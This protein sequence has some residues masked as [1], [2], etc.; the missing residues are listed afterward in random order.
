MIEDLEGIVADEPDAEASG[1]AE[2]ALE[3]LRDFVATS[4]TI[5]GVQEGEEAITEG[6]LGIDEDFLKSWV[7]FVGTSCLIA[8][9]FSMLTVYKYVSSVNS[10]VPRP[11]FHSIAHMT[12]VVAWE[13]RQAL[14]IRGDMEHIQWMDVKRNAR[15]GIDLVGLHRDLPDFDATGLPVG[16]RVRA[17][18]YHVSTDK[19]GR[20]V[21]ATISDVRATSAMGS[22]GFV[23][24]RNMPRFV[25]VPDHSQH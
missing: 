21:S 10:Q 15:G 12:R 7:W 14:E 5:V 9:F 13:A 6:A 16:D 23:V 11:I 4:E 22:P 18:R 8:F 20:I 25:R 19:W 2:S 3:N 17:Q 1:L 24:D